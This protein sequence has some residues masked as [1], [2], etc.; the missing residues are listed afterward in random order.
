[1]YEDTSQRAQHEFLLHVGHLTR[2]R[3][4]GFLCSWRRL[5]REDI[6]VMNASGQPV[7][8]CTESGKSGDRSLRK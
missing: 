2:E 8:I 4:P 7:G 3:K 6:N 5:L 1:M